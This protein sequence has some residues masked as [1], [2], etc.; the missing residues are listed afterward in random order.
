MSWKAA[1]GLVSK[2]IEQVEE[3]NQTI[4]TN[5]S[6]DAIYNIKILTGITDGD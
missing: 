5:L 3:T 4:L 1:G 6:L 2:H